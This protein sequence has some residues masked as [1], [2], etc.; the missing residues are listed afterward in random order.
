MKRSRCYNDN[1]VLAE[2]LRREKAEVSA[3]TIYEFNQEQYDRD[4][5]E[6]GREEGRKEGREEG[7]EEGRAEE[8]VNTE[9]ERKRAEVAENLLSNTKA[10]LQDVE[11]L[12]AQYKAEF[13]ELK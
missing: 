12:L 5:R 8:R 13:G 9:R 10:Q 2:F 4:L 7:R 6:E 3:M 1:E 11:A